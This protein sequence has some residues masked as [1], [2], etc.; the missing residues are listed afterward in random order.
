MHVLYNL[1]PWTS[2]G[3]EVLGT[4]HSSFQQT[5][6]NA[7]DLQIMVMPLGLS[8]DN[9]IVLKKALG[10]SDKVHLKQTF[11]YMNFLKYLLIYVSILIFNTP[12]Y[13][14]ITTTLLPC[15]IIIQ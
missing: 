13:R 1:G 8:K 15:R 9:G 11:N 5:K 7:P 6:L 2:G 10:I 12:F 4:L 14:F 3:V